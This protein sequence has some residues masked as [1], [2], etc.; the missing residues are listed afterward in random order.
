MQLS[1]SKSN[2]FN[3]SILFFIV[4]FFIILFCS[5]KAIPAEL[6]RPDFI[7]SNDFDEGGIN[8]KGEYTCTLMVEFR[9]PCKH[10]IRLETLEGRVVEKITGEGQKFQVSWRWQLERGKIYK[11]YYFFTRPDGKIEKR[12]LQE[13]IIWR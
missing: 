11:L 8:T 3:G 10:G 9:Q 12:V 6:D 13:E 5:I 7:W 1:I 4:F 2:V